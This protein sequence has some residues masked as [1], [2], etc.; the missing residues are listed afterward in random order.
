MKRNGAGMIVSVVVLILFNVIFCIREAYGG[1]PSGTTS[2]KI[3]SPKP[4]SGAVL[5]FT[6]LSVKDPG[7]NNIEAVSFLI[8]TGWKAEGG[9]QWFPDY[10]VLANLLMKIIDPQTGAAIEFLPAQYFTWVTAGSIPQGANYLGCIL[11][12]PI[13]DVTEFIQFFYGSGPLGR[14]QGARAVK[15][16]DLPKVAAQLAQYHGSQ[17]R[18]ARVRYEY[19]DRGQAWEEDVYVTLIYSGPTF[20]SGSA[21]SYRAHRGQLDRFTPIMNTTINTRRQSPEWFGYYPV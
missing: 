16:E 14:L 21:Y 10:F 17:V 9:I 20:W 11:W 8:P 4:E 13:Q 12:P 19:Q 18:C 15:I 7:A 5:K 2:S 6:R 3:A 1:S